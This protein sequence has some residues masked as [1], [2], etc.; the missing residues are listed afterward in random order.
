MLPAW[1]VDMMTNKSL[2]I[3]ILLC[4]LVSGFS[5]AF[6]G[7]LC[8][9]TM[10]PVKAG[11]VCCCDSPEQASDYS[12]TTSYAAQTARCDNFIVLTRMDISL[13]VRVNDANRIQHVLLS[14]EFISLGFEQFFAKGSILR[15]SSILSHYYPIDLTLSSL[16]C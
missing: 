7:A 8:S 4:F 3:F 14:E 13:E 15:P 2:T 11:Q 10:K 5:S 16:R 1:I 9:K 12:K 6:A